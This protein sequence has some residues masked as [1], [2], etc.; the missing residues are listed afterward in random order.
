MEMSEIYNGSQW[1][2][3]IFLVNKAGAAEHIMGRSSSLLFQANMILQHSGQL[4]NFNSYHFTQVS[5]LISGLY[6]RQP[7]TD[8][9]LPLD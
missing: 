1:A 6:R 2:H 5:S 4:S 8:S 7:M 9:Q 3:D